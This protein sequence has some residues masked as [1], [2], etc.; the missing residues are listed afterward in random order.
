[1]PAE[2]ESQS[3]VGSSSSPTSTPPEE[4]PQAFGSPSALWT[5]SAATPGTHATQTAHDLPD[6]AAADAA[7]RSQ[8]RE[9]WDEEP[10]H[11]SRHMAP[12]DSIPAES[13]V[14]QSTSAVLTQRRTALTQ[15]PDAHEEDAVHQLAVVPDAVPSAIQDA[16]QSTS[17][18]NQ[19]AT[20]DSQ[21][22]EQLSNLPNQA[23]TSQQVDG[24][25]EQATPPRLISSWPD[26]ANPAV[27]RMSALRGVGDGL[28][29][30]TSGTKEY[31]S[32]WT[33][34]LPKGLTPAWMRLKTPAWVKKM[35]Q[36]DVVS[37]VFQ[38]T[39]SSS[40]LL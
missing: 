23:T 27:P 24:L 34:P 15:Q 11:V 13:A 40:L 5:S 3:P 9:L 35:R 6:Q 31:G 1:M 25:P 29:L 10:S 20:A 28:T 37:F 19:S 12:G 26:Q 39:C 21:S 30:K 18:L 36:L 38:S 32:W 7:P 17:L 22:H 8:W 4:A 16:A 33:P 14:T 2:R